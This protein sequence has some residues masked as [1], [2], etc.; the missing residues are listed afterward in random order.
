MENNK[1]AHQILDEVRAGTPCKLIGQST[2][3]PFILS[4]TGKA[5]KVVAENPKNQKEKRGVE[6]GMQKAL[7]MIEFTLQNK[8][9]VEQCKG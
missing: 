4:W 6:M 1:N 2:G 7:S 8:L 5:Y 3:K 9:E